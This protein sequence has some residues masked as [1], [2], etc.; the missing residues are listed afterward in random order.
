MAITEKSVTTDRAVLAIDKL[1]QSLPILIPCCHHRSHNKVTVDDPRSLC[2]GV[3]R[4][5]LKLT[6]DRRLNDLKSKAMFISPEMSVHDKSCQTIRKLN[7]IDNIPSKVYDLP[8]GFVGD[9]SV[10]EPGRVDPSR[11]WI[12]VTPAFSPPLMKLEAAETKIETLRV[13]LDEGENRLLGS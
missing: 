1:S 2:P 8:I 11:P 10:A 13:F 12:V 7:S 6:S 9:T 3:F 4:A 5:A